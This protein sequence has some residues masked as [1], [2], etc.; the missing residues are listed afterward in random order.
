MID[1]LF[2]TSLLPLR[3]KRPC[4]SWAPLRP[5]RK[6]A[7]MLKKPVRPEMHDAAWLNNAWRSALIRTV[8]SPGSN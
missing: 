6:S 3:L 1:P 8:Q 4:A 7:R 2:A 5:Q